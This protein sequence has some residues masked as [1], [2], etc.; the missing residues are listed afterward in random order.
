MNPAASY[1]SSSSF[2]TVLFATTVGAAA[3]VA[4]VLL[5][6]DKKLVSTV[7]SGTMGAV[8]NVMKQYS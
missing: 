1:K 4:G 8:E 5:S 7:I 6:K 2:G 3:G